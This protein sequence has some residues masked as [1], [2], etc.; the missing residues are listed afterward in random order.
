MLGMTKDGRGP[1]E[2]L[3]Q[4]VESCGQNGGQQDAQTA[5]VWRIHVVSSQPWHQKE[6]DWRHLAAGNVETAGL[7]KNWYEVAQ[8]RRE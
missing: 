8:G 5:A 6:V 7:G 4:V 1:L 3:D 2:T